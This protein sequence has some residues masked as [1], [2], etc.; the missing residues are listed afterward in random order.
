MK[1][2]NPNYDKDDEKDDIFSKI[3]NELNDN[4]KFSSIRKSTISFTNRPILNQSQNIVKLKDSSL[5]FVNIEDDFAKKPEDSPF[6]D[7]CSICSSKIYYEK[8]LCIICKDCIIC[9]NCESTHLHPVIKFTNNLL[10]SLDDIFYFLSYNNN[11]IQ[12]YIENSNKG[13]FFSKSKTK[14]EFKIESSNVEYSMDKNDKLNIPINIC[15]LNK[16]DV[17]CKKIKLILFGSNTKDLVVHN[18]KLEQLIKRGDALKTNL[19]VES[20]EFIKNYSFNVGLYSC[21]DINIISNT[22]AVK[23]KIVNSNKISS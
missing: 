13:G 12:N 6:D 22:L 4:V 20:K 19:S 21:E 10:T 2:D 3:K 15:N 23:L 8:Y 1:E 18:K 11:D 14:Y 17:D 7:V 5:E 9:Q 16:F